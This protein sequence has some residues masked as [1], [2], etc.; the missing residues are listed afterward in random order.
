V[1]LEHW[2]WIVLAVEPADIGWFTYAGPRMV[3]EEV[4]KDWAKHTWFQQ[5]LLNFL[6][7][8]T[9]WAAL[10]FVIYRVFLD[11]NLHHFELWDAVGCSSRLLRNPRVSALH[12]VTG[13]SFMAEK[14]DRKSNR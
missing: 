11:G 4:R 7:C 8:T 14:A 6:G 2:T 10:V 1:V 5:C 13:P 9:G 3:A 12:S